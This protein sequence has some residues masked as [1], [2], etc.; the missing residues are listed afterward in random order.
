MA[1]RISQR[2]SVIKYLLFTVVTLLVTVSLLSLF[3][4]KYANFVSDK[5]LGANTSPVSTTLLCSACKG[6]IVLQK[7]PKNLMNSGAKCVSLEASKTVPTTGKISCIADHKLIIY[8]TDENGKPI[9]V[10]PINKVQVYSDVNGNGPEKLMGVVTHS[11]WSATLPN[12]G[13][14]WIVV[15][16]TQDYAITFV[17]GS[18]SPIGK[19]D[20]NHYRYVSL[21][22]EVTGVTIKFKKMTTITQSPIK[23]DCKYSCLYNTKCTSAN[24]VP[25]NCGTVYPGSVCCK[26]ELNTPTTTPNVTK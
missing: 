11:Q 9:N 19:L 26:A 21:T 22:A 2:K 25:S 24:I 16:N 23:S 6:V 7:D 18:T 20:N 4:F 12:Y 13:A 8:V 1:K 17:G 15:N 3:V 10:P 5:V 14:Y